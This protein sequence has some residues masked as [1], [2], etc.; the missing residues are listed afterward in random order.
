MLDLVGN[1]E[2]RFSHDAAHMKYILVITKFEPRHE[3]TS[4]LHRQNKAVDQLCSNSTADQRL[5]FR[6]IDSTI[7][8]LSKSEIPSP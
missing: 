3:K 7:S 8:P 6:Y 4:F 5:Y 2:E 1:P